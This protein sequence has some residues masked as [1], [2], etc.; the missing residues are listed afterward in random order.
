MHAGRAAGQDIM[1]CENCGAAMQLVQS[2]RYFQC[3]HCGTFHFPQPIDADGIRIV[4]RT[5]EA[6]PCPVCTVGMDQAV[7]DG[8]HPVTFCGRCRGVLLPRATFA[9]VVNQRRAWATDPPAEPIP[10]DRRALD[11]VLVCPLCRVPFTTYPYYG[12]GNVVIDGCAACDVIWLDFGEMRQIVAAPGRDRGSRQF[13]P[14]ENDSARPLLPA[15][16]DSTPGDEPLKFLFDLF[17]RD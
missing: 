15:P 16:S 11:R 9:T 1:N 6:P 12:P 14:I 17:A 8:D 7:I 5:A 4:G 13:V 10:M 3:G 2:R